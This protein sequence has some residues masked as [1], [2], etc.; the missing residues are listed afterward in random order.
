VTWGWIGHV[1]TELGLTRC[2][3]FK[4]GELGLNSADGS[5]E[6]SD[7]FQPHAKV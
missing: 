1:P 6:L 7:D 3:Y 5:D 2:P 4:P